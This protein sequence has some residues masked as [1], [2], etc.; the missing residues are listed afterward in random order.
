MHSLTNLNFIEG[1][2]VCQG[3]DAIFQ[4]DNKPLFRL[5][6]MMLFVKGKGSFKSELIF[7]VSNN[8]LK[9]CLARHSKGVET[10]FASF[11]ALG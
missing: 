11:D 10:F 9:Q 4:I 8:V 1:L 3:L 2:G 6:K 5:A 7:F